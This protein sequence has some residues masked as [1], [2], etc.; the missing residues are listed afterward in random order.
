MNGLTK[1]TPSN[2]K[3]TG[4][5]PILHFENIALL[6]KPLRETDYA[7]WADENGGIRDGLELPWHQNY[8]SFE[9]RAIDLNRPDAVQYRWKLEGSANAD[10]SPLSPQPSI[11]FAGLPPG[12][13]TFQVQ[14]TSDGETFSEPLKSSFSI[15]IPFWQIGWLQLAAGIALLGFIVLFAKNRIRN[16]QKTEQAKREKLEMQNRMLQLEQKALQLQMNPHFIF[17]ALNSI[18][19]LVSSGD[20]AAARQEINTFAKLMRS[21]L[22]NSRKQ[23][24]SL[25]EEADTLEQYL[26]I[27][28]FCQQNKFEFSI[29]L[30]E[31]VDAAEVELPPMLLQPF[32]ENA[33][34]HGV[35]HL[36]YEG[37]IDIHFRFLS[38]WVTG[39]D[40]SD[41]VTGT[42][43]SDR[44]TGTDQSDRV[45]GS[46]PV[47]ANIL[48][49]V[50]RDN[51]VGREKSAMLRQE[52][53][54]GHASIAVEV[55]RERLE[56]LKNGYDYLPLEYADLT[57]AEGNIIG[58]Q[59]VVRLP[60]NMNY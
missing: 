7:K 60:A 5:V 34:V 6:Y 40:Q 8:L 23:T 14:A 59:V 28:Q 45:T 36:K 27:E 54:P 19:S 55:T 9:Y 43:Q 21:I 38:D 4:S 56:A 51:G 20:S 48:E 31:N 57:G 3:F 58:T 32:A 53:M 25:Q 16:I 30:P 12:R 10:W 24:I 41:R 15:S 26:R 29:R 49:C 22:N 47:T 33:V 2:R 35:S 17:N 44:V 18:Q 42:D 11:N 46:H 37:K 13:Y 39:T 50:I 52:R 1:Y